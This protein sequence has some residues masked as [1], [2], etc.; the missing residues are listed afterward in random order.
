ME[1]YGASLYLYIAFVEVFSLNSLFKCIQVYRNSVTI[2]EYEYN[3]GVAITLQGQKSLL[4][5]ENT[6]K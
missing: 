3:S 1:N 4:L 5:M 2:S 6:H